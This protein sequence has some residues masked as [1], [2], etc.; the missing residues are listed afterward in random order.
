VNQL[1]ILSIHVLEHTSCEGVESVQSSTQEGGRH[2]S[3]QT[4][5]QE[6]APQPCPESG[7][8][9]SEIMYGRGGT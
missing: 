3:D 4:S 9:K 5:V 1:A 6:D 2:G 7:G 8:D